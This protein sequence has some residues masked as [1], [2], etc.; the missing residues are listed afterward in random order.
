MI[1]Q[2]E[3]ED[4]KKIAKHVSVLN[5]EVGKLQNDV[6]WIKKIVYYMAGVLSISV[7]KVIIFG[8]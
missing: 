2:K 8:G 4:L 5:A 6:R 7:G 1:N 3:N